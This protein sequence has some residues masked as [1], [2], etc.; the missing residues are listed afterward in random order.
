MIP[1]VLLGYG[2]GKTPAIFG[3]KKLV[4]G[5]ADEG[6]LWA[7]M[8]NG[9]LYVVGDP[10]CTGLGKDGSG[11]NIKPVGWTKTNTGVVDIIPAQSRGAMVKKG[12]GQYEYCYAGGSPAQ[13]PIPAA[14]QQNSWVT[15]PAASL[16]ADGRNVYDDAVKI[17]GKYLMQPDGA[18]YQILF[19]GPQLAFNEKVKDIY[20][21][22]FGAPAI[23]VDVDGTIKYTGINGTNPVVLGSSANT[24]S[25]TWTAVGT[26][27]VVYQRAKAVNG[28]IKDPSSSGV[29]Q[30]AAI[31]AQTADGKW[32]GSGSLQLLGVASAP[33][34]GPS[35]TELTNVPAGSEL[36]VAQMNSQNISGL[37]WRRGLQSF[38]IDKQAGVY[39]SAG[40][41]GGAYSLFRNL[42]TATS[43]TTLES[44]DQAIIDDGGIDYVVEGQGDQFTM[45]VTNKGHIFWTG[46]G[47]TTTAYPPPFQV[48]SAYNARL[49]DST[50]LP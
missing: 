21:P 48:A 50:L 35:L 12:P 38:V 42:A 46:R 34:T 14:A 37:G 41:Q 32:W 11:V 30:T 39:K 3:I 6:Q 24:T 47:Y 2:G 15:F 49:D 4:K 18:V 16:V 29:L 44:V 36:S 22:S 17:T 40:T 43:T 9:D 28:Q 7:L 25:Y 10:A 8:T 27:G 1:F 13:W 33:S 19:A 31:V 20:S 45:L 23:R 26:P 5:G